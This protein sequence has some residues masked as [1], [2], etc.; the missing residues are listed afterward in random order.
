MFCVRQKIN[1]KNLDDFE[2]SKTVLWLRMSR[3]CP[4]LHP[5]YKPGLCWTR[6]HWDTFFT[7]FFGHPCLCHE[8]DA[9][10]PYPFSCQNHS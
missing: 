9:K 8:P 4:T 7:E 5:D 1:F 10:N 2:P 6:W 3:C